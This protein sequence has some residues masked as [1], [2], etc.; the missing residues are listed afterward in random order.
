MRPRTGKAAKPRK[1]VGLEVDEVSL[2]DSPA[3]EEE[4]LLTKRNRTGT[5]TEEVILTDVFAEAVNSF[6]EVAKALAERL[7]TMRKSD[8][9][10]QKKTTDLSGI[11]ANDD[12][13]TGLSDLLGAVEKVFG[14]HPTPFIFRQGPTPFPYP[15]A[16]MRFDAGRLR[17]AIE[18]AM[19]IEGLPDDA[20]KALETVLAALVGK[21]GEDDTQKNYV[22]REEFEK[23]T[24]AATNAI[25]A[26]TP[27]A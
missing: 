6:D 7:D 22:T 10:A 13:R 27:K 23:F 17:S 16:G 8:D 11:L 4:F 12:E 15:S 18:A 1:L 19:K 2:V 20:K 3:N 14:A 24:T 5:D 21:E 26:L 25:S 9:E